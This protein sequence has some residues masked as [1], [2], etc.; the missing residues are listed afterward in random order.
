MLNPDGVSGEYALV[1]AD[2]WHG[3]GL[4][5]RLMSAI[6]ATARERGLKKFEGF[7]LGNNQRMLGLMQRLGYTSRRDRDDP[8]LRNV[9]KSL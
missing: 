5:A 6:E 9:E 2:D 7:V 1:V 8:D 4:G 3:R